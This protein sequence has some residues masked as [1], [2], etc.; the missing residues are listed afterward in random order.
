MT[1]EYSNTTIVGAN[2]PQVHQLTAAQANKK[3]AVALTKTDNI[4]R[5]DFS[6]RQN[7]ADSSQVKADKLSDKLSDNDLDDSVSKLNNSSQLISRNLQFH[8]DKNSGQTV[9]TVRDTNSNEVI[10]QIPSEQ[11]L[12]ISSRLKVL[13][14]S[15]N[16]KSSATGIFFTSQT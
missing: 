4:L 10:R 12:E 16:E 7:V 6:Q 8:I 2:Q 15:N 3:E 1:T 11:L 5:L 9:I 13:Q 14:E